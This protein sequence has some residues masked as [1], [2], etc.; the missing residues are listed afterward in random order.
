MKRRVRAGRAPAPGHTAWMATGGGSK[1]RS[2]PYRFTGGA[3]HNA[4]LSE[5]DQAFVEVQAR[6]EVNLK[7]VQ[8]VF[9]RRK[10]QLSF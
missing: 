8:N 6:I 1:P 4:P 2:M 10:L 3:C 7:S 5:N 9:P